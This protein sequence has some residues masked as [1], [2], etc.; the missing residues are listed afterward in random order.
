MDSSKV[1]LYYSTGDLELSIGDKVIVPLGND[2]K[3]VKGIVV[4]IGTCYTS[5]FSFDIENMKT[6]IKVLPK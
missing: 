5:L 6:V 3:E 4:S 1:I 2:N